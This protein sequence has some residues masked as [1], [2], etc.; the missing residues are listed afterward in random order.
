VRIDILRQFPVSQQIFNAGRR[1]EEVDEQFLSINAKKRKKKTTVVIYR[2]AIAF[3][4]TLWPPLKVM[5]PP[6]TPEKT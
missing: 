1:T 3:T 5:L 6:S 2:L 4:L